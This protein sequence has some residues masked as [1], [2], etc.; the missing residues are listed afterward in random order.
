MFI[1]CKPDL[2]LSPIS[3]GVAGQSYVGISPKPCW[4]TLSVGIDRDL[5]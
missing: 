4:G 3:L 5:G 1:G 2:P